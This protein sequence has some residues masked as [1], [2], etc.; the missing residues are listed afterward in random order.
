[1]QTLSKYRLI[2]LH[3][4]LERQAGTLHP[5]TYVMILLIVFQYYFSFCILHFYTFLTD[6][7]VRFQNKPNINNHLAITLNPF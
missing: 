7:L 1:M 2:Y 6:Q 5:N 3:F 4:A